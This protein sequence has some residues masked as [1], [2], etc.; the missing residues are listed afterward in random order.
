MKRWGLALVLTVL[1][2]ALSGSASPGNILLG[3]AIAS[4]FLWLLRDSLGKETIRP[5]WGL[6][7][8][9]GLF[10]KELALSAISV[11]VAVLKPRMN[12]EPGMI[13]FPLRLTRDFE[14][15]LLAN[16]ITLTP[17]TLTVD[18][19]PDRKT[20]LIHAL[21]APDPEALVASIRNGFETRILEAFKR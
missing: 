5:T 13:T 18:V 10:L 9:A 7:P 4:F 11:A 6:I 14:I 21:N 2:V 16:L 20:L 17:G 12:I 8:L 19:G 15:T 1:W 3:A